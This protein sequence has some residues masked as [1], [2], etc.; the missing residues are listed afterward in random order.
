MFTFTVMFNR[1]LSSILLSFLL[2]LLAGCNK[3]DDLPADQGAVP[4]LVSV[5]PLTGPKG[6]VVEVRGQYF[7]TDPVQVSAYVGLTRI[8][9]QVI[10]DTLLKFT[11]PAK[12]GSGYVY[13]SMGSHTLSGPWFNYQ[14][15]FTLSHFSGVPGVTGFADGV[16]GTA[17]FNTPRGLTID[18]N[19]VLHVADA[20]NHA[21]RRVFDNGSV[22]TLAGNG[23]AGFADDAGA[24][25]RF[26]N[27]VDVEL[28][29]AT[30]MLFVA[31]RLNHLIRRVTPSGEVATVAGLPAIAG[32][33]DGAGLAARLNQPT[34]ITLT[35][36]PLI[37]YIADA[38]NHCIRKLNQFQV[39]STFAGINQQGYLDAYG[40]GARFGTPWGIDFD[41][42]GFLY[43]TDSVFHNIRRVDVSSTLVTTIAGT[44]VPGWNDGSGTVAIFNTPAALTSSLGL[45]LVCDGGNHRIRMIGDNG[46]VVTLAGDGIPGYLNGVGM[47]TRLSGPAGIVRNREGDYFISDTQ[48]HCI[49]KLVMD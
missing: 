4:V 11:L 46:M 18:H 15:T 3:E 6:T 32:Y 49:R 27:P 48:N 44:G 14:Y 45:T 28:D 16:A 23:T 12:C 36:S 21:I 2:L 26:N 7:I 31:D 47:N 24:V 9:P 25:A 29:T 38:A 8:Q 13:I 34:G 22:I 19:G 10:S 1:L 17:L 37:L 39:L 30:G 5:Q 40:T 42:L 20:M 33:V 43:V 35:S 41:T